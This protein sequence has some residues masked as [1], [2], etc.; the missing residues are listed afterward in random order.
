MAS[1]IFFVPQ[2]QGSQIPHPIPVGWEASVRVALGGARG[3]GSGAEVRAPVLRRA[4]ASLGRPVPAGARA[5]PGSVAYSRQ[6]EE[7]PRAGRASR[8]R[9]VQAGG[10]AGSGRRA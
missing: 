3:G 9:A 8:G 4:P 6:L 1:P 2:A 10:R 5:A 7:G